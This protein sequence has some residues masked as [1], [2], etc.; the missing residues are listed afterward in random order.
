MK[1]FSFLVFICLANLLCH[2]CRM[3]AHEQDLLKAQDVHRIMQQILSQHVDTREVSKTIIK[4]S[5]KVYLEQFDPAHIYLLQSETIPFDDPNETQINQALNQYRENNY[6]TYKK[7]NTEIQKSISRA[8]LWRTEM[9]KNPTPYFNE[10]IKLYEKKPSQRIQIQS[11]PGYA[12][13]IEEL[14][15]R[16]KE[17]F[18]EF[19]DAQRFRYGEKIV[20]QR[21]TQIIIAYENMMKEH[22]NQYTY[23]NEQGVLL[24]EPEQENLFTLH[25]LKALASSLDAHTTFYNTSEAYDMK[26]RLKKGFK[27]I[28]ASFSNTPDG[29]IVLGLIEGGPAYKTGQIKTNDVLVEI[30]EQPVSALSFDQAMEILHNDKASTVTLKLKH[31]DATSGQETSYK[32]TI[33]KQNIALNDDRAKY[34][35]EPFGDGII[36][37]ITLNSFY[38]GEN[39]V[40]SEYDVANAIRQLDQKGNLRGLILDLRNNSGGFLSQA[41]KVAGLFITNGVIVVSKYSDGEEKIY[42]DMDGKTAYKGPLIIL[43]SKLTASAAEIVAQALQD[44]GIG[45]IVGDEHT[46]GKGTIQTQTVTD[47]QSSSYF[48]VTV[49][50]YYTVSGKTPQLHGVKADIVVPGPLNH[51]EIGEEYLE[52]TIKT[53]NSND[54]IPDT[55]DDSLQDIRPNSRAWYLKYYTPTLQHKQVIWRNMIPALSKNS[56]Y[57]IAHNKNYQLLLKKGNPPIEDNDEEW[58]LGKKTPNPGVNDLQME[59]AVNILKDMIRLESHESPQEQK[60]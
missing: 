36:G 33:Q 18:I 54:T 43:T 50:T 24:P 32:V 3:E 60:K 48:K 37:K 15:E 5:F 57:R 21:Q 19:I 28:G 10:Y 59:E 6:S 27:G 30:N 34:N 29:I 47:N 25:I 41:V 26:V 38:Q 52:G 16:M 55:Y 14:N 1:R 9:A 17:H 56:E 7:L 44:Y 12:K 23:Q 8:R 53:K 11:K 22:E 42:R 40:T 13:N 58:L 31:K 46:F 45:L 35:S 4:N 49:G 2:F 51:E 20:L 39:G